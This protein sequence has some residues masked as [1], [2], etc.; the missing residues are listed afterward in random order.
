MHPPGSLKEAM[1]REDWPAWMEAMAE[2]YGALQA[3]Q[4]WELEEESKDQKALSC[5]WV[6][7]YKTDASGLIERYKARLVVRGFEQKA[8]IDYNETYAATMKQKTV[9]MILGLAAT[10]D[11]ELFHFD[12]STAFLNGVLKEKVFMKQPPL[13]EDAALP[14]GVCRLK[15]TL[16]GLKQSPREWYEEMTRT[17][18]EIGF[19]RSP[20]DQAFFIRRMGGQMLLVGVWVDDMLVAAHTQEMVMDLHREL[21]KRYKVKNLGPVKVFL[22]ME[23]TRSRKTRRLF[24]SQERYLKSVLEEFG[25]ADC[26]PSSTPLPA[27]L[28]LKADGP[29]DPEVFQDIPYR[30]VVGKLAYA[31]T[32]TRPDIAFAV[33]LVSRY[34]NKPRVSHWKAVKHVLSYIKGTL[35]LGLEFG[36]PEASLQVVGYADADFAMDE[37]TSRSVSGRAFIF[38]GAAVSW[39][40]QR[41]P[42]VSLSTAEAEYIA[43]AEASADAIW[44]RSKLDDLGFLQQGPT[45]IFEDNHSAIKLSENDCDHPKTRHVRVKYHFIREQV[46]LKQVVLKPVPTDDQVADGLTKPLPRDKHRSFCKMLGLR[47]RVEVLD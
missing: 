4:T 16:Y 25:M 17:L 14:A 23:V 34:L 7:T 1:D 46:K 40:S 43:A 47:Q 42:S 3:N 37:D 41:Q 8:G 31:M 10:L 19:T 29:E 45:V 22:G 11:L 21:N 33:S 13:F 24:L 30:Q 36:G 26:N 5:K 44:Y 18:L 39:K 32:G 15:K 27:G 2:E 9:R 12:L 6:F 20:Y 35:D 28:K 38:G